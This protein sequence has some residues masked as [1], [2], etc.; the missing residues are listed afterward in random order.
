MS[1]GGNQNLD[2]DMQTYSQPQQYQPPPQQ[3]QQQQ[4]QQSP[5]P[6][7]YHPQASHTPSPRP[8]SIYTNHCLPVS[9]S[10]P[11][12]PRPT[13]RRSLPSP[14]SIPIPETM[15]SPS[16]NYPTQP[17][18]ASITSSASTSTSATAPPST[19]P[20][21][22]TE[23]LSLTLPSLDG[24][25]DI[26]QCLWA[27]DVLRVLER[28]LDPGGTMT[29]LPTP[30][31]PTPT[32]RIPSKLSALTDRAVPIIISHTSHRNNHISSLASYLRG[33]LLASGACEDYLPRDPRQAFKDFET[34]A[35]GGEAK[36][37]YRLGRDYETVGDDGRAI[38]CFQRGQAKGDCEAT[39]VSVLCRP[40]KLD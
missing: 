5:I 35:R 29:G 10:A 6:G 9:S 37:W 14:A 17:S 2:A 28:H 12:L 34:A 25:S 24:R 16:I 15:P 21:P 30:E 18:S 33:K 32:T 38:D 27:Q 22:T 39:Y 19:A 1:L 3:Q 40:E 20:F 26:E 7:S 8:G 31:I 36:A 13:P 11:Q 4:Y 23:G